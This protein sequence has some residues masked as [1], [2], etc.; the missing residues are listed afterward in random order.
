[1][2]G[3]ASKSQLR[4]SFLRYALV[5]VPAVLLLGALSGALAGAGA[6]NVWYA[7]LRK[8]PLT[9]PGWVFGAV[10]TALYALLGVVLA[11]LLHAKGAKKRGRLIVLL[12]IGLALNLAW[13]PVFFR[14]HDLAAALV[15][16]AAMIVIAI[17]L[18][19]RLW[20]IRRVA[21]ALMLLYLA[22]LMFA[23]ALNE[24]LLR[25]NPPGPVAPAASGTNIRL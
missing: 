20:P 1:M 25:L 14:G 23:G 18:A 2:T 19:H 8:P 11:M 4:M 13:S 12:G 9:P 22:W 16:L 3:L 6:D 17:V 15:M 24:E 10:W 21:A 7:A 5:S